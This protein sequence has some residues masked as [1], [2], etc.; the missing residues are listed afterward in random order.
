MATWVMFGFSTLMR[1][2]ACTTSGQFWQDEREVGLEVVV[3]LERLG[4]ARSASASTLRRVAADLQQ[5]EH[6]RGE[7]V[8]Q[9]DA[10]EAHR[11]RRCRRGRWR[12][13]GARVVVVAADDVIV[14]DSAAISSSSAA[15]LGRLGAVVERRDQLDRAG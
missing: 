1:L 4:S 6:E 7:L 14:S 2:S 12:T 13:T 10:G 9:R 5:G 11:R 15:Q 8:A 3:A